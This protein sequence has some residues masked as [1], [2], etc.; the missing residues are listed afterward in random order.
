MIIK[1]GDNMDFIEQT[2][3]LGKKVSIELEDT[4]GNTIGGVNLDTGECFGLFSIA[5]L[6]GDYLFDSDNQLVRVQLDNLKIE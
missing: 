1:K 4:N 6:D 3:K 2:F 5:D